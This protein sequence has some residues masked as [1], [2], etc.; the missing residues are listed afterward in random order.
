MKAVVKDSFQHI[1]SSQCYPKPNRQA[2]RTV[3]TIKHLLKYSP[4]P[5]LALL[6]YKA[7]DLT[8][9]WCQS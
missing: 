8:L 7:T 1:T 5:F 6:S 9:L 2:K 4:D 3:K